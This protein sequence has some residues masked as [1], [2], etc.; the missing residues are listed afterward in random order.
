M[1][2]F[3]IAYNRLTPLKAMCEWLE[4]RGCTPIIIDNFSSYQPLVRW[5][6]TCPYMVHRM[7]TNMGHQVFWKAEFLTRFID[8]Y[9]I[10]TDPDLDLSGVPDDFVDVLMKGLLANPTVIKSGLSLRIDDLPDNPYANEVKAWEQKYWDRPQDE[11]GFY[12]SEIDTTLALYD[13]ERVF[14]QLPND[15]FFQAVRSPYP[16]TARH[17]PW[18]QTK[19][20]VAANEEE[21]YYMDH[22]HTYWSGKFKELL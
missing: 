11:H 3:I 20:S 19:E 18:Y 16:Y 22:T 8:R 21:K 15:L 14:G 4:Q 6:D 2:V 12:K 9:Y 17:L 13:R 7:W 5:Y 10:V 1:K